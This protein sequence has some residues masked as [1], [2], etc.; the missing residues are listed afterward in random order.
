MCFLPVTSMGQ[1]E[2]Q[3]CHSNSSWPQAKVTG[4]ACRYPGVII[5][6][7]LLGWCLRLATSEL[8]WNYWKSWAKFNFS[9]QLDNICQEPTCFSHLGL[10]VLHSLFSEMICIQGLQLH[11]WNVGE[12]TGTLWTRANPPRAL[13]SCSPPAL[14]DGRKSFCKH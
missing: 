6:A 8:G 9:M 5:A 3:E 2:K 10:Y 7:W 12:H 4:S 1:T 14:V 13:S 11:P